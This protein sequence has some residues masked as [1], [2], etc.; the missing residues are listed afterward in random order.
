MLQ[1][2]SFRWWSR[3]LFGETVRC[4]RRRFSPVGATM[5]A[6]TYAVEVLEPRRLLSADLGIDVN[7]D[8]GAVPG[9]EVAI[10]VFFRRRCR[11]LS[12]AVP[13]ASTLA[14]CCLSARYG[15]E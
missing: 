4:R 15:S 8:D 12:G 11:C 1:L 14:M 5:V 2:F 9:Q 3:L 13:L 10:E 7:P 6:M